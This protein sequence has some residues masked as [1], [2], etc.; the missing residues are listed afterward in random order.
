MFLVSTTDVILIDCPLT[1]GYNLKTAIKGVTDKSIT[2]SVYSH[3]HA[4]HVGAAYIFNETMREYI[5]HAH[6]RKYLKKTPDPRRSLPNTNFR[7]E[8]QLRIENQTL[9]LSYKGVNHQASNI[10][11]YAPLVHTLMLVDVMFPD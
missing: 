3:A 6:T 5:A 9:E 11:V 1:L 7:K 2:H 8:K 10:F 4:D